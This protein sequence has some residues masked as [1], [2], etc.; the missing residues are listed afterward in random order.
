M[1]LRIYAILICVVLA[2]VAGVYYYYDAS[3]PREILIYTSDSG[4]ELM[5]QATIP[6]FTA[7]TGI[8]VSYVVPGGSG[9]VISKII[10]EKNKPSADIAIASLP[11]ML[12]GKKEDALEKYISPEAS[13]IPSTFKDPDG[14][15]TGWYAFHTVLAY[16]PK[17][18]TDPPKKF[19]DLLDPKYKGKLAYPD[20]TTSG[21]GLRF[22]AALINTMGEDKAFAFLAQ[23]EPYIARHDS[24]PLGEFINKG[25]LWIQVSD[26]SI[27]TSEVKK[28]H[29]TDQYMWVTEEGAIAGYVAIAITKG[30]PHL[31]EAKQ[32]IDFMLTEEGQTYVTNGYGYPCREGMT[33]RIPQDLADIWKPFFDKPVIPLDWVEI[34]GKTQAWRERW[35]KEIQ[36]LG[37]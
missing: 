15:F 12:G 9:T 1:K 27:I 16:N 30:A 13:K 22:L 35:S 21:N 3:K 10:A 8:K 23:L 18:V 28:E 24:L 36:P 33:N 37:G 2:S 32:L 20:P 31:R 26:D 7:K 5:L 4:I 14:Y 17:V 11:S 34:S 25:E 6:A 29:M 19:T